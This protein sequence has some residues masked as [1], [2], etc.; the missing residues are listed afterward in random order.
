MSERGRGKDVHDL[1]LNLGDL[2]ADLPRSHHLR[3]QHDVQPHSVVPGQVVP[4][5]CLEVCQVA[6]GACVA[7]QTLLGCI[8]KDR[9]RRHYD[10]AHSGISETVL[11][12]AR[13]AH[14]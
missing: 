10:I 1:A 8:Q 14:Q 13:E 7:A 3:Q 9:L 2:L 12:R 4:T 6:V 5:I 11:V